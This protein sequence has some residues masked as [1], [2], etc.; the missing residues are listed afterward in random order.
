MPRWRLAAFD[1]SKHCGP[2][3]L[4]VVC[5]GL[6]A[7]RVWESFEWFQIIRRSGFHSTGKHV[8]LNHGCSQR[9]GAAHE[10]TPHVS[11]KMYCNV[12]ILVESQVNMV[13][14]ATC[15]TPRSA[16][17]AGR[18]RTASRAARWAPKPL[19]T[20]NSASPA[21]PHHDVVHV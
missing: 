12:N 5:K 19:H 20:M 1:C 8:P 18:C 21:A 2:V 10:L 17:A 15:L 9:S 14:S 11:L 4:R 16:C 3:S 13:V 6:Q 7:H